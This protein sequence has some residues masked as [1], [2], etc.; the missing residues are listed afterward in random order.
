MF[1]HIQRA[2][3]SAAGNK[4]VPTVV[5]SELA[6]EVAEK[7]PGSLP[8]MAPSRPVPYLDE[9]WYCCAEPMDDQFVSIGNAKTPASK[10]DQF[11]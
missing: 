11:V 6:G 9:P 2:A 1:L 7:V 5:S 8:G 10:A 4:D 3:R